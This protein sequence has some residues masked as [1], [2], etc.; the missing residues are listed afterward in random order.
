MVAARNLATLFRSGWTAI[1]ATSKSLGGRPTIQAGSSINWRSTRSLS[2][3]PEPHLRPPHGFALGCIHSGTDIQSVAL[4]LCRAPDR[5]TPRASP[6]KPGAFRIRSWRQSSSI[7]SARRG[8]CTASTLRTSP[9]RS[10]TSA[11]PSFN[12]VPTGV[13][14]TDLALVRFYNFTQAAFGHTLRGRRRRPD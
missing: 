3:Q 7:A 12:V 6:A 4:P 8:C 11:M 1:M 5:W 13:Q 2:C 9:H 14:F 10:T